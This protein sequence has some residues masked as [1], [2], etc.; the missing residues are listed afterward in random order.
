[1][2][3]RARRRLEEPGRGG[4]HRHERQA[5]ADEDGLQGDPFRAARDEDRVGQGVDPVDRENDV[6]RLG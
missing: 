2:Q 6:G 4:D 5:H 3:E 1:L